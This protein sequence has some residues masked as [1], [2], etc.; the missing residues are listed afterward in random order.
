MFDINKILG[1]KK[2]KKQVKFTDMSLSQTFGSNPFSDMI[3]NVTSKPLKNMGASAQKQNQWKG[4]SE[5]KRNDMRKRYKDSDGEIRQ[6]SPKHRI[7]GKFNTS[8]NNVTDLEY[9]E[10]KKN[11]YD[12]SKEIELCYEQYEPI[13]KSKEDKE[14]EDYVKLLILK[15]EILN[16]DI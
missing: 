6:Y 15:N 7:S 8:N 13:E 9:Q 4:F 3:N 1:N 5:N 11:S 2:S 12:K 14:A 10:H 16:S